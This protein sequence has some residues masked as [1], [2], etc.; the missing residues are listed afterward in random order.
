MERPNYSIVI[1][2]HNEE[3]NVVELHRQIREV[4]ESMPGAYE[5]I[6]INDASR[7]NT[8]AKLEQL[9]QE[10]PS[11]KIIQFRRQFGQTAAW[12]AGF[13]YASGKYVITMDA[14]LQNDPK[15]IPALVKKL[16]DEK[17]DVV[18]GWRRDRKD[19]QSFM[20]M[21]K[22][23]NW[24]HRVVT[25]EK[26][27]D[28]G[29]SLKIYRA[30]ALADIELYSEMRRYIT[31]LL[32]WKGFKIGEMV[33]QHH[34][35]VAGKTNYNFRKKIKA[36]LDL[37]VVKFWI[38]YSSRPIHFFGAIGISFI[39]GGMLLGAVILIIWLLRIT[40]FANSSLPLIAVVLVLLGFQFLLTGVLAD[41]VSRTYYSTKKT[42]SVKKTQGFDEVIAD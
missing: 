1:P 39:A 25:G 4:L 22:V 38:Q 9:R 28:H 15:D 16:E 32:S 2:A 5:I 13:D 18:S 41:V 19:K 10:N 34:P 11:V 7:D 24:I 23:G 37:L 8:Q 29:C 33:V 17:L 21:S 12:W 27:H 3:A 14:D 26:I 35:R 36:F 42:Y 30:E 6:F 40:G 31:A 20:A